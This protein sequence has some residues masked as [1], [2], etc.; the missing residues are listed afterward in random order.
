MGWEVYPPGLY[1]MLRHVHERYAP[2]AL[3]VTENGAAFVDE[4][5]ADGRIHDERRINYL[6]EHFRM[7]A[8]AIRDGVPLRGYFVWSLMDNFEWA[9]GY[10]KRFG[11]V[12]V[13][14]DDGQRR[15]LKDSAHFYRSVIAA[16]G[17]PENE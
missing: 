4:V 11:L 15:I 7:A 14:F 13:D 10:S 2:P 8:K 16:N 3:Y 5:A 17:V 12:Y 6:R 9:H 1:N